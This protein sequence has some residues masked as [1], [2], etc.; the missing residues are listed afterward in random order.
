M[1]Q[2]PSELWDHVLSYLSLP[3]VLLP[4]LLPSQVPL[5][6]RTF[7]RYLCL[8]GGGTTGRGERIAGVPGLPCLDPI[9]PSPR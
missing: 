9:Q 6:Q 7:L 5:P 2:L 4:L 3:P 8:L 1:E